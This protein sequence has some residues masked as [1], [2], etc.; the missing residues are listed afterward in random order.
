MIMLK[1]THHYLTLTTIALSIFG[2]LPAT[3]Q[4][5][6]EDLKITA[7]DGAEFDEFGLSITIDNGIIAVGAYLDDDNGNQSGSAYVFDASTGAQLFK[8]L[9]SDGAA[10][11]W[12]GWS[13][14]I[15]NGIIAVGAYH[16]NDNGTFAGSAYLF[17]SSTGVQLIKLLAIDGTLEDRFGYSI[18]ID[19]GVV[20][21]GAWN[22]NDNGSNSGSAYLFDA[23][24]GAQL[25]KLLPNDGAA[26]DG[27]GWSIAINNGVVAIG[28]IGD[29]NNGSNSGSAYLFNVSTGTQLFKLLPND[30]ATGDAFGYSI[31]IDNGVVAVGATDD[32]DNGNNSGSVYLF[33]TST[34]MQIFKLL[35]HDGAAS[36]LFGVSIAIDT[37][38]VA[39]GAVLDDDNGL[40]SGSAYLFDAST[41]AQLSKLLPS[42]GSTN[43]EF[44]RSIAINHSGVAVGSVLDDDNSD[45]SG[46]AYLFSIP[47]PCLADLTGDSVLNFFDVSLFLLFFYANDPSADFNNDALFNFFDVSAFI[48]AFTQGCP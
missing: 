28:A 38:V 21:V 4:T 34:G 18:A 30:G 33:D 24:T 46:S 39:V 36:D 25:F 16:D 44:G 35:P 13:I 40:A 3:G 41:G 17:D 43:D 15:D 26:D 48:I 7:S 6:N 19:D 42:D 9:P 2:I 5:I 1:P 8:L 32:D 10:G 29:D 20:A 11:D 14:A 23:S 27:F 22:D 37:G 12:F 47:T 31:A 45:G